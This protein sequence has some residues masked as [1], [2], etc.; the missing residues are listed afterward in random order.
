LSAILPSIQSLLV[1]TVHGQEQLTR[2]VA[3]LAFMEEVCFDMVDLSNYVNATLTHA[4][5]EPA[6]ALAL[7]TNLVRQEDGVGLQA[8]KAS[9][10][11]VI[12]NATVW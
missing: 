2:L 4:L 9:F 8:S 3:R 10:K 1:H 5:G 7:P 11:S 6:S 12:G